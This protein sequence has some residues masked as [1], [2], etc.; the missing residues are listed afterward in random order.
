MHSWAAA[1]SLLKGVAA[2]SKIK[3]GKSSKVVMVADHNVFADWLA[4][5]P[6]PMS[7]LWLTSWPRGAREGA[8]Q[9]KRESSTRPNEVDS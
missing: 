8:R 3:V 7:L 5:G 9:E 1:S 4:R 6:S 2:G